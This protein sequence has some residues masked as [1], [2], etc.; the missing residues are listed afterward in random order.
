LSQGESAESTTA[1]GLNI[2]ETIRATTDKKYAIEYLFAL[3]N[4]DL[5]F[6]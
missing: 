4:P 1:Y 6:S 2:L 5:T 3:G